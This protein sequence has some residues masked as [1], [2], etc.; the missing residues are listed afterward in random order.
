MKFY[1]LA[2]AVLIAGSCF[3]SAFAKMTKEEFSP[4]EDVALDVPKNPEK[5]KWVLRDTIG[6]KQISTNGVPIV[7]F[8]GDEPVVVSS[9]SAGTEIQLTKLFVYNN[10]N[11]WP[12]L[13][14]DDSGKEAQGWVSGMFVERR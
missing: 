10:I 1:H 12:I 9:A 4:L 14:T 6:G 13:Y 8:F 2:L 5:H 7:R 11:Y 3:S